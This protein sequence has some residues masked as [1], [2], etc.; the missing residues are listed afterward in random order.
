MDDTITR[1]LQPTQVK[2]TWRSTKKACEHL[3]DCPF[4]VLNTRWRFYFLASL[5]NGVKRK[6]KHIFKGELIEDHMK[7]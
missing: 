2:V 6:K 3:I 5:D 4:L 1:H 7:F